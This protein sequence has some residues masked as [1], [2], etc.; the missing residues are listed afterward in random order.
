M[1][2]NLPCVYCSRHVPPKRSCTSYHTN[3]HQMNY[4]FCLNI[5]VPPKALL[6]IIDVGPAKCGLD[7]E[8]L[9]GFTFL[10]ARIIPEYTKSEFVKNYGFLYV[11]STAVLCLYWS[12]QF[13]KV[14]LMVSLVSFKM[15]IYFQMIFH[16]SCTFAFWSSFKV[17]H[18]HITVISK[19]V[20]Y[21]SIEHWNII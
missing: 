8:A 19:N 16:K 14:G 3:Q 2:I 11:S 10:E 18:M 17:L 5:S 15:N 20:S 12:L 21:I 7:L 9:G 6:V 4:I 1:W 13:R